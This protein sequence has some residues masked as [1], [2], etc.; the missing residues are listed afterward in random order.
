MWWSS[1]RPRWASI[2]ANSRFARIVDRDVGVLAREVE[3]VGGMVGRS[4]L[5]S[6]ELVGCRL[7]DEGVEDLIER[8]CD[9]VR[10]VHASDGLEQRS[11]PQ[12]GGEVLG[13]G[14]FGAIHGETDLC[15]PQHRRPNTGSL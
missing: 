14:P 9:L 4:R 10:E 3:L 11:R 15:T 8:R 13:P 7:G 2:T 12:G 1:A 6:T 5:R